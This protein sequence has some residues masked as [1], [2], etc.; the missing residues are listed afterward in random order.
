[1]VENNGYA[2]STPTHR[3]F[4]VESLA[5]RGAAYGVAS[6]SID[7]TDVLA[8]HEATRRAVDRGRRGEGPTLLECR[9]LRRAG[10]AEHDDMRYVPRALLE[11]WRER[12]PIDRFERFL[13]E[14]GHASADDLRDVA[15][16]LAQIVEEA[17]SE[18]LASPLPPPEDALRNVYYEPGPPPVVPPG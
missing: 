9:A 4:A 17:A 16:S 12:D 6:E 10:H 5:E 13:V 14:E 1:V 18:A 3:Q 11:A 15:G 7:G 2:Y 8:V